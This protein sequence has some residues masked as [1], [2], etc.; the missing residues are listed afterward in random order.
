MAQDTCLF[1]FMLVPPVRGVVQSVGMIRNKQ[2]FK[3]GGEDLGEVDALPHP[4]HTSLVAALLLD[5]LYKTASPVRFTHQCRAMRGIASYSSTRL[6]VWRWWMLVPPPPKSNPMRYTFCA[7][8]NIIAR[9][10]HAL[11]AWKVSPC[12]V[13]PLARATHALRAW[14]TILACISIVHFNM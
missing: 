7:Q 14:N 3:G 11:R 6:G 4:L 10:T 1:P 5:C 12:E 2:I 8:Q 13:I 9:A